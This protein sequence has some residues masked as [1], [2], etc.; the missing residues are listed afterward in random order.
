MPMFANQRPV[1]HPFLQCP[2]HWAPPPIARPGLNPT[3]K[4]TPDGLP[5]SQA[6]KPNTVSVRKR[7]RSPSSSSSGSSAAPAGLKAGKPPAPPAPICAIMEAMPGMPPMPASH[8]RSGTVGAG[9]A[10]KFITPNCPCF[11]P[12]SKSRAV[13]SCGTSMT[14]HCKICTGLS[15]CP[16]SAPLKLSSCAISRLYT[17]GTMLCTPQPTSRRS[18]PK[19]HHTQPFQ[20]STARCKSISIGS[21]QRAACI[22]SP[23]L[24]L[25]TAFYPGVLLISQTLTVWWQSLRH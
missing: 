15:P 6:C 13:R 24:I 21:A 19:G 22:Y 10:R 14:Q 1:Y 25:S 7:K 20:G 2:P 3:N 17:R 4:L 16:C 12:L 9:T 11:K 8:P 18:P 23:A 5:R